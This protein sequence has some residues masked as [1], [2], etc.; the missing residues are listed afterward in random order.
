M[1]LTQ[2]ELSKNPQDFI[3]NHLLASA[4]HFTGDAKLF[5]SLYLL[6]HG[7][8]KVLLV[9]AL[10]NRKLSAYPAAIA[11]FMF[12]ILYQLYR[13]TLNHSVWLIFLSV[14]DVFVV[15]LT[16]MEYRRISNNIR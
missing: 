6:S 16:W 10:L 11:F 12:F 2:H 5:G 9:I 4:Q 7:I 8:V 13:Y 15:F 3:A 14:F 1:L